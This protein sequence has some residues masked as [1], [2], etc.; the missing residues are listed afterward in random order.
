MGEHVAIVAALTPTQ[1]QAAVMLANGV[2][3]QA[4]TR[5]LDI[6]RTTLWEWEQSSW[7][8]ACVEVERKRALDSIRETIASGR[9]EGVQFLRSLLQDE[10]ALNRDRLGAALALIGLAGPPPAV[11]SS[12]P[13]SRPPEVDFPMPSD[14]QKREQLRHTFQALTRL[15][16]RSIPE[17]PALRQGESAK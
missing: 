16:Q 7:F 2:P 4:I 14:P 9:L 6:G 12:A 3:R 15:V 10:R 11:E 1:G 5:E 13:T 8:A 17:P